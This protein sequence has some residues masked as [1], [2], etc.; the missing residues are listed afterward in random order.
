MLCR[1]AR[2]SPWIGGVDYNPMKDRVFI[3]ETDLPKIKEI[4]WHNNIVSFAPFLKSSVEIAG[5]EKS[6]FP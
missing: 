2:Q 3:N 6:S 4:F 5:K 1:R